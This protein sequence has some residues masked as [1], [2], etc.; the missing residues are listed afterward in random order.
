M[1]ETDQMLPGTLLAMH[2][3]KTYWPNI[4][5]TWPVGT[6]LAPTAEILQAAK[7]ALLG[8]HDRRVEVMF[9]GTLATLPIKEKAR[10]LRERLLPT[11]HTV[12]TIYPVNPNS[13][14]AYGYYPH[15]YW[16]LWTKQIP[17]YFNISSEIHGQELKRLEQLRGWLKS[18]K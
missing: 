18:V 17:R 11:R 8:D 9:R 7:L 10:I 3:I 15:Y 6:H 5:I 14:R 12:G 4:E 1:V 2:L 16:R 13:W